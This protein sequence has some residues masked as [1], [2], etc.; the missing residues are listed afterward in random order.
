MKKV[1]FVLSMFLCSQV[2]GQSWHTNVEAGSINKT[3]SIGPIDRSA[4]ASYPAHYIF[5]EHVAGYN[6]DH[7]LFDRM[8]FLCM[9]STDASKGACPTGENSKSSQGETN[10]KLIFTEK[11]SLARKTLN[12]KGYKRF[13]YESDRCI[14]Y[15]NKMNLNSHTVRCEGSFTRG[16][17]FTLYIPQGEIDGLLTG[18][19]WEATLELRVK[20]HYDYNHGTYKVNITVDLT[21]KGNIQVWTPKFHSDPRIDLNLRPEGNGKYSGSNV[22]EMCLYDGYSTHSQ[23]IEM[24]FQDDSQTGNNEYNLIKTGEPL[25]KLPYKLSLLLGGRE[26]YPNNGEA[27]TINDTSS[28][29]INWNRIKSV[30]LPQI[31]IPVLCWP[32]NLTFMS[33]LNNPEAGEYSGILNVTFTPSSSSL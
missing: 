6:K 33:E 24:R 9:S 20:R 16:V 3:E 4:A 11:K 1:I 15:V 5:H 13:L 14:H 19:I 22:L 25:K 7:S 18:G 8:T 2:Y 17:D 27:F 30:S 31:S 28:L 21:D 23:S 26:F 10:I 12:L 29:F 32:A